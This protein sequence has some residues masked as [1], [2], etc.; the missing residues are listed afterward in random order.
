M[1]HFARSEHWHF[2]ANRIFAILEERKCSKARTLKNFV[3]SLVYKDTAYRGYFCAICV[4]ERHN[5]SKQH[6][7][8]SFPDAIHSSQVIFDLLSNYTA[9]GARQRPTSQIRVWHLSRCTL[10]SKQVEKLISVRDLNRFLLVFSF[11]N[12]FLRLN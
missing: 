1:S 9:G 6:A 5:L 12:K 4:F 11:I 7:L 2:Y 3:L 8:S 10:L